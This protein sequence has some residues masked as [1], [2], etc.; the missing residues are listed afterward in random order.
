M[1]SLN[2]LNSVNKISVIAVKEF[3]PV[4]SY[5]RDQDATTSPA[6]YTLETGYLN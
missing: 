4:T 6:G 2:L 3:E 1:F 5:V